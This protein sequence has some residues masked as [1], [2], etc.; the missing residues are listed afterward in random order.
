MS[1]KTSKTS[2][3]VAIVLILLVV[4]IT[5]KRQYDK[6]KE[7]WTGMSWDEYRNGTQ[8]SLPGHRVIVMARL[9]K[10]N[11]DWVAQHLPE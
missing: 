5:G 3:S 7:W 10:E 1:A 11:T 2:F 8:Q 6:R 9:E 4:W